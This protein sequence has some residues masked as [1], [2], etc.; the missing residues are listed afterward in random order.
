[1][2]NE[3]LKIGEKTYLPMHDCFVKVTEVTLLVDNKIGYRVENTFEDI[4][5]ML[6]TEDEVYGIIK[7]M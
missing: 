1:M 6:V 4:V 7:G 2:M 5:D 3:T